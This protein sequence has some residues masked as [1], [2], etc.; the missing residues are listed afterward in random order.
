[1]THALPS[2]MIVYRRY[3]GYKVTLLLGFILVTGIALSGLWIMFCLSPVMHGIYGRTLCLLF[4][5]VTLPIFGFSFVQDRTKKIL[6][7]AFF[8]FQLAIATIMVVLLYRLAPYV[9]YIPLDIAIIFFRLLIGFLIIFFGF[10]TGCVIYEFILKRNTPALILNCAGVLVPHF[11][12]IPWNN[13][14]EI[15]PPSTTT[16]CIN[17]K[18]V[19]PVALKTQATWLGKLNLFLLNIYTKF[20]YTPYY[21]IS[22]T[23]LDTPNDAIIAFANQYMQNDMQN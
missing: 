19:A 18:V 9:S 11:G 17:I 21:H 15:G 8:L 13:I 4:F 16:V 2:K 3:E 10:C 7:K 22:I 6:G 5:S 20:G 23:Y 12:L 1:M 14:A